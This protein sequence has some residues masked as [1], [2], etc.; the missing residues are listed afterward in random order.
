V[1][2]EGRIR[3][4]YFSEG[5]YD[6]SEQVI[7]SLLQSAGYTDLPAAGT[8]PIGA[9]GALAAADLAQDQSPETYV[10]YRRA[11]NFAARGGIERDTP[12]VYALPSWLDLNHWGLQGVWTVGPQS[13]VLDQAGGQIEYRF[14]ARDL[15]LVLGIGP[16]AKPVRF[17]VQLDG[18]DPGANHGA[19]TDANGYG[20]ITEQRLYQLIR[21]SGTVGEHVFSIQFLDDGAQ[22]YAFTFG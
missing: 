21:Q 13:A 10:G 20:V 12:H 4:E 14:A 1:D 17:R 15:H 5:D 6:R 19:D 7:R 18:A 8:Q 2:A 22:A 11:E 3:Y 16:S 9:Q